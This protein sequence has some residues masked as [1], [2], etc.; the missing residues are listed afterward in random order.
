M[1]IRIIEFDPNSASDAPLVH[2]WMDSI[3]HIHG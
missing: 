3:S 1:T 2:R